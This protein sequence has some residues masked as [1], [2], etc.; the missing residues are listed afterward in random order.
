M[1]ILKRIESNSSEIKVGNSFYTDDV[2]DLSVLIPQTTTPNSKKKLVFSEEIPIP[3]KSVLK[4]YAYYSLGK[5]KPQTVI[6]NMNSMKAFIQFC[7]IKSIF[8]LRELDRNTIIDFNFWLKNEKKYKKKSGYMAMRVVEE[9]LHIG[10][11]KGWNVP[12]TDI[13]LGLTAAEVWGSGKDEDA[14]QFEPIP[15]DIFEKIVQCAIS[16]RK[17]IITKAGIIIQSQ[18]GLRIGEVLSLKAGCLHQNEDGTA[19][20]D[21]FISKTAKGES[22]KH[23]IFANQLVVDVIL[24]LEEATRALREESGRDELFLHRNGKRICSPMVM[25]WSK[26]RLRTFIRNCN[27]RDASGELYHLQSHQFRPTFVRKIVMKGIPI[28]FAMK[29]FAHVSIEMT[30]HYLQLQEK[31]IRDIYAGILLD[32]NSKLAGMRADKIEAA[33]NSYFKGK[34]ETD[35]N[36]VVAELA[37]GLTFNPLPSGICL[38]DYRRGNCGEGDSCFFYNCPNFITEKSFLPVLERELERIEL[39]MERE[40]NSGHER[41]WQLQNSKYIY[42]KPLIEQLKGESDE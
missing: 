22:I 42:L 18:T 10:R 39:A 14:K 36:K 6:T 11:I 17:D 5:I 31:E 33:R 38:Y 32:P 28:S 27:I 19:Y 24:E 1:A 16:Y 9:L 30:C 41:A 8:S 37:K 13:L 25:N 3:I 34:A 23:K 29:Q 26:N 12:S 35:V 4:Q 15:D 21:V 40:K 20:F 2:W 7:K